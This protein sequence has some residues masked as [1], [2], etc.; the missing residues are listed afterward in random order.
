MTPSQTVKARDGMSSVEW[1]RHDKALAFVDGRWRKVTLITR[2]RRP[3]N[4]KPGKWC[5]EGS[6][7]PDRCSRPFAGF[8]F[9]VKRTTVYESELKTRQSAV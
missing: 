1:K 7:L 5:V 6:G 2:V 4:T 3:T 9:S 8:Y